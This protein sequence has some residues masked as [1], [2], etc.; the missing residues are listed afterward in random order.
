MED[1]EREPGANTTRRGRREGVLIMGGGR[2]GRK[3]NAIE[4]EE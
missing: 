3:V 2:K 1:E 4:R